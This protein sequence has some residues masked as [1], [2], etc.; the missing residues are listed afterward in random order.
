MV[1]T[2]GGADKVKAG[3]IYDQTDYG[4]DGHKGWLAAAQHHKVTVVAE[5][6]IAPG[7]KDFTAVVT[8]L[9]KAGA[10]HVLLTVL[11]S[12]TGPIL[13]TAAKMSFGPQWLGNTP[14]WVDAF[15]AH[16]QLPPA[17]FANFHWVT[18][19]P[20]WGEKVPGMD[21]FLAAYETHGKEMGRPDFYT[22]L[23]Y[24]AGLPGI[25]AAKRAIEGGDIS[26]A[27]YAKAVR[28]IKDWK[29]DGF[30]EPL[31]FSNFPYVTTKRTRILKPDFEKKSWQE[32]EGY[33]EPKMIMA[34]ATP[35]AK[36]AAP[37]AGEAAKAPAAAAEGK[38]AG[39]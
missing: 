21:K 10:T 2:A 15:F 24:F 30:S 26:P 11:P 6:P 3:I 8:A 28:S 9:K 36:A 18:S 12:S 29:V 17:V 38:A 14:A 22:L 25:E 19:A 33:A 13:G 20:F 37:A 32:V 7:Q 5:Q 4:K 1:Q 23:S 27:G 39:Q 31:N 35:D 16:P 34:A